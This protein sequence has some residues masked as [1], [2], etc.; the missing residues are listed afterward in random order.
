MA[1]WLRAA[2]RRQPRCRSRR[3]CPRTKLAEGR[4]VNQGNATGRQYQQDCVQRGIARGGDEGEAHS[5]LP[6]EARARDPELIDEARAAFQALVDAVMDL[7][8][9]RLVRPDDPVR[10]SRFVWA[11]VHGI[12]MLVIEGQ[13]RGEDDPGNALNR[14]AAERMRAA[15]G[16]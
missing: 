5:R 3:D 8:H 10:L 16:P 11:V 7:Q 1:C 14:Y 6:A 2:Q 4:A 9:E 12:A 15:L 13:L